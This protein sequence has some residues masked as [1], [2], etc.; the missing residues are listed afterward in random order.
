MSTPMTSNKAL[1]RA[2]GK[3][4]GAAARSLGR[5]RLAAT[6]FWL[7][8]T[9]Q[10]RKFLSVG[11]LLAAVLLV[12]GILIGPA[13]DGRARL[14]EELPQLR[15]QA[16]EVQAMAQQASQLSR[17]EPAQAPPMTRDSLTAALGARG[18]AAQSIGITGEYAKVQISGV[19]F[20][21]L[22]SW[23]DAMR[24]ENR[25]A[26]QDANIVPQATAGMVDAT[27][28]LRQGGGAGQ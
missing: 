17:A 15:Q 24:R 19:P 16:A 12:Y 1:E 3:P 5:A 4:L 6:T 2:I 28:T 26:V 8:R 25:I 7:A 14:R 13:L 10:E 9:E 18:L 11:G 21:G 22:V 27:L 23:L 20:A